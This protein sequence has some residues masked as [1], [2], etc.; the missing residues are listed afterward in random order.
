MKQNMREIKELINLKRH[1]LMGLEYT[2]SELRWLLCNVSLSNNL[3]HLLKEIL[4][5]ELD[6]CKNFISEEKRLQKLNKN[7]DNS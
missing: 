5:V 7:N 6:L 3:M 1:Y 4:M 2:L